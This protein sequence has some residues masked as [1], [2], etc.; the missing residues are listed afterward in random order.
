ME[1]PTRERY[2]S[3]RVEG[4]I[5]YQTLSLLLVLITVDTIEELRRHWVRLHLQGEAKPNDATTGVLFVQETG[6]D[7]RNFLG[8]IPK[9]LACDFEIYRE[10]SCIDLSFIELGGRDQGLCYG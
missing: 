7:T 5:A 3:F 8:M 2:K 4:T 1:H 9:Y 6:A 10:I